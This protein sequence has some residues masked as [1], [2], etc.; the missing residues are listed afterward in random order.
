LGIASYLAYVE[1]NQ[2]NALCGP[3]GECNIVQTSKYALF[4]GVPVAVWGVLNYL[5]VAVLWAGQRFLEGRKADLSQSGLAG[6]LLFGTI[7]S[8]Y[9]TSLELFAIHAVCIWCLS[10]AVV[11]TALMLIVLI[12]TTSLSSP[13]L[14]DT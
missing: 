5:S 11:T 13:T 3:V 8:I 2:V 4:L 7:F 6:L 1:V 14:G 10:S 12:P 9:L